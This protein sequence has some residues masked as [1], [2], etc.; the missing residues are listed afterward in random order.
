MK[1]RFSITIALLVGLALMTVGCSV[2]PKSAKRQTNHTAGGSFT[3]NTISKKL[4]KRALRDAGIRTL[5]YGSARAYMDYQETKLRRRLKRTGVRISRTDNNII[6]TMPGNITFDFGSANLKSEFYEV[7]NSVAIVMEEYARTY[8]D[9]YGHTDS[10]GS[11]NYNNKLSK[12]RARCVAE[13][14]VAQGCNGQRFSIRGFG[15]TKPIA[16]NADKSGR[17][18]NRRV[19]IE[20]SPLI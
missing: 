11:H 14:L 12:R 20:I 9:V 17:A 18:R 1:S 16:S 8:I 4:R 19:E 2:S 5:S 6:L 10:I 3:G 15:E 13:Y 7:L